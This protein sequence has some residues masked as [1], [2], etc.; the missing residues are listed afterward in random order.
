MCQ[1]L[2]K[3]TF[4]ICLKTPVD[5]MRQSR[6]KWIHAN[7]IGSS[8]QL[9]WNNKTSDF[10]CSVLRL[11]RIRWVSKSYVTSTFCF[12]DDLH[13]SVWNGMWRVHTLKDGR[14]G[15]SEADLDIRLPVAA[16]LYSRAGVRGERAY[17]VWLDRETNC[18]RTSSRHV[19]I[20]NDQSVWLDIVQ[21]GNARWLHS[22][23]IGW[24]LFAVSLSVNI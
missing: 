2:T 7:L 10:I 22:H 17:Y 20:Q 4:N 18:N 9:S 24:W 3:N 1:N 19:S 6:R 16:I 14:G 21:Q 15:I 8:C 11:A 13:G 23:W 5:L 12:R